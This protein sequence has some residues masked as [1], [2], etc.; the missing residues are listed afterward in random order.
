LGA[1]AFRHKPL[2][3]QGFLR[4]SVFYLGI[5]EQYY[6]SS[7]GLVVDREGS[8]LPTGYAAST[9]HTQEITIPLNRLVVYQFLAKAPSLSSVILSSKT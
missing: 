6:H 3:S 5:R 9:L 4:F 1:G 7:C 2:Y 8:L